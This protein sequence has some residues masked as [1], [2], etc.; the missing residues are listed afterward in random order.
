[1]KRLPVK[2]PVRTPVKVG[3]L[4]G[5]EQNNGPVPPTKR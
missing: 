2:T 5:G 3:N 1:M 4:S